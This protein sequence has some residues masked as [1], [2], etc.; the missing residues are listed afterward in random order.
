MPTSVLAPGDFKCSVLQPR[1]SSQMPYAADGT[2][3]CPFDAS[4]LAAPDH[5]VSRSA[6]PSTQ[7][8]SPFGTK[9]NVPHSLAPHPNFA[10]QLARPRT[11][12]P[13]R[14]E[15][16]RSTRPPGTWLTTSVLKKKFTPLRWKQVRE[17]NG[18][19]VAV[20]PE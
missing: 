8:M 20:V 15:E 3:K 19:W 7:N 9:G 2:I 12:I 14:I 5:I 6:I 13:G 11:P 1:D 16:G 4:G 18:H 10:R 17:W